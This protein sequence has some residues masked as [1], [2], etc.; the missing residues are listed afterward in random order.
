METGVHLRGEAEETKT[1]TLRPGVYQILGGS[2]ESPITI[3]SQSAPA[4]ST[5]NGF[6][7]VITAMD[8]QTGRSPATTLGRSRA[9]QWSSRSGAIMPGSWTF[10]ACVAQARQATGKS[11]SDSSDWRSARHRVLLCDSVHRAMKPQFVSFDRRST[12]P[13][14]VSSHSCTAL[15]G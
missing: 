5:W 6:M 10:S 4:N 13:V 1:S 9:V 11:K 14:A 7:N 15:G 3:T 12:I 8:L 2:E